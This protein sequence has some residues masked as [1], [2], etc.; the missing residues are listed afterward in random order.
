MDLNRKLK[1]KSA[2]Y[3]ASIVLRG[4]KLNSD[5]SKIVNGIE[6]WHSSDTNKNRIDGVKVGKVGKRG[7]RAG[8]KEHFG[9]GLLLPTCLILIRYYPSLTFLLCCFLASSF[10]FHSV[11][12]SSFLSSFP[13]SAIYRKIGKMEMYLV[14]WKAGKLWGNGNVHWM[15]LHIT[16]KGA[17]IWNGKRTRLIFFVLGGCT[18]CRCSCSSCYYLSTYFALSRNNTG[19][20]QMKA[21]AHLHIYTHPNFEKVTRKKLSKR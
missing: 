16:Q 7:G 12:P 15:M 3:L 6:L 20:Y 4:T 10:G 11:F 17:Q 9:H 13:P 5:Y 18:S 21:P 2:S 8:N 1:R 19:I 14:Q